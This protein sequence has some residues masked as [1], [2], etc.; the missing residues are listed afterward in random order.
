MWN[1]TTANLCSLYPQNNF[2][3][4]EEGNRTSQRMCMFSLLFLWKFRKT[5]W[6]IFFPLRMCAGCCIPE[7]CMCWNHLCTCFCTP[8]L[9]R[10]LGCYE[11][12]RT[13]KMQHR[14]VLNDGYLRNCKNSNIYSHIL[15][16]C[17][18]V[19]RGSMCSVATFWSCSLLTTHNAE[20]PAAPLPRCA[21]ISFPG[22]GV[23]DYCPS[24]SHFKKK[25]AWFIYLIYTAIILSRK[26]AKG[27]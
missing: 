5:A 19:E 1:R 6:Q 14:I 21:Y 18:T 15:L 11:I 25:C 13:I 12:K 27:K 17:S 23:R 9:H 24:I 10:I 20:W 3:Q 4:R 7:V 2:A 26:C 16:L 22:W 8:C